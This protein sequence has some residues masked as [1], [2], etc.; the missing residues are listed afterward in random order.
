MN[1]YMHKASGASFLTNAERLREPGV[2]CGAVTETK[3][4]CED[5]WMTSGRHRPKFVLP[6]GDK[7]TTNNRPTVQATIRDTHVS[8]TAFRHVLG[9]Q[10]GCVQLRKWRLLECNEHKAIYAAEYGLLRCF[11]LR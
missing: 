11:S 5:D 1:G 4:G 2:G 9:Q 8:T 3:R 6:P 10:G 7:I